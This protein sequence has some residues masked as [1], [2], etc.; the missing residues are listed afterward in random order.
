[1]TPAEQKCWNKCDGK[2][3]AAILSR[4]GCFCGTEWEFKKK[5]F[6]LRYVQTGEFK[7]KTAEQHR[8][9]HESRF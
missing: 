1:M 3:K 9:E 6:G 2:N 7:Y 4:W 8:S 5:M